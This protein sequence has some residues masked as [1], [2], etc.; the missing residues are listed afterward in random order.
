MASG[1]HVSPLD[2]R[3]LREHNAAAG[4]D[5]SSTSQAVSD[6]GIGRAAR[7]AHSAPADR[8]LPN[9]WLSRMRLLIDSMQTDVN[10]RR[11]E[12]EECFSVPELQTGGNGLE[13]TYRQDLGRQ[14][15]QLK[16][17]VAVLSHLM[18]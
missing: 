11:L 10:R 8:R 1:G 14:E 17:M 6:D 18:K 7:R 5:D 4:S 16:E 9:Y 2:E 3:H 12:I 13:R 15:R